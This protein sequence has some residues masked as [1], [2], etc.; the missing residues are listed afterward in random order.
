MIPYSLILKILITFAI[1][2]SGFFYLKNWKDKAVIKAVTELTAQIQAK[3]HEI[4]IIEQKKIIDTQSKMIKELQ[5]IEKNNYSLNPTISQTTDIL[6]Q[7]K[8]KNQIIDEANQILSDFNT[9][10]ECKE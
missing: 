4:T 10:T 9:K 2:C 7:K 8:I 5:K 3:E 1:F 6:S